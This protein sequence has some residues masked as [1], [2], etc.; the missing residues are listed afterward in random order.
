M[1]IIHSRSTVLGI[2]AAYLTLT[3]MVEPSQAAT[4]GF[5][6]EGSTSVYGY[7]EFTQSPLTGIGRETVSLDDLQVVNY[8]FI[9]QDRNLDINGNDGLILY[10]IPTIETILF[11]FQDGNLVGLHLQTPV[12]PIDGYG[13]YYGTHYIGTAS[14]AANGDTFTTDIKGIGSGYGTI[15]EDPEQILTYYEFPFDF[16]YTQQLTFT[17]IEPIKPVD[18]IGVP[19]PLTLLGAATA[20]GFGTLFKKSLSSRARKT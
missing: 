19:E 7:L 15:Y 11:D 5:Q 12:I 4:F 20:L 18:P 1:N 8:Q 9:L 10:G 16:S 6:G 3:M 2:G 13:Y 17:T 14:F